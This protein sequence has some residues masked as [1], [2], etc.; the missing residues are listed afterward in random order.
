MSSHLNE[1]D[2][3]GLNKNVYR[4]KNERKEDAKKLGYDYDEDISNDKV[5]VYTKNGKTVI[6]HKGTR[7]RRDAFDDALIFLGLG[8]RTHSQRNSNRISRRAREKYSGNEI[9]HTGHSLGGYLAEMTAKKNEK[10][11]TVNKHNLGFFKEKKNPNV[12][13]YRDSQDLVSI[14]PFSKRKNKTITQ[15]QKRT[16]PITA[17]K[18]KV[19]RKP[20][21]RK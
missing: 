10:V 13:N 4:N 18:I 3:E 8:H 14:Q 5:G 15:Y 21:V 17:H 12:L 20:T 6:A 19:V 1:S 9:S 16:D 11:T 2:I 7:T